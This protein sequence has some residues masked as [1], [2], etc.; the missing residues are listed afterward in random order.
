M[1][2]IRTTDRPRRGRVKRIVRSAHNRGSGS[3][4]GHTRRLKD[5]SVVRVRAT[6]RK[7]TSVRQHIKSGQG[8][9]VR[10]RR[11]SGKVD[12]RKTNRKSR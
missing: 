1:A 11:S 5:G 2:T 8:F 10:E 3:V 7:S 12:Y 4:V 9:G 6:R